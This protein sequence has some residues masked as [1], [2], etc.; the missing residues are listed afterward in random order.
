MINR[1][2]FFTVVTACRV[3]TTI[4]L[5]IQQTKLTK[6]RQLT[7][8][9]KKGIFSIL[10]SRKKN[11]T[12]KLKCNN[13]EKN[14]LLFS[15]HFSRTYWTTPDSTLERVYTFKSFFTMV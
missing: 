4:D 1:Q 3:A 14:T 8:K 12:K 5:I 13:Y 7:V 9:L 11:I 6:I 10:E 15:I 2:I